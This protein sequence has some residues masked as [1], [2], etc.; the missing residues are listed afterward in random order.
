M[1]LVATF[2]LGMALA[3]AGLFAKQINSF[4]G[5]GIA[6]KKWHF[7]YTMLGGLSSQIMPI[8]AVVLVMVT[9]GIVTGLIA[10][11]VLIIGSLFMGF[12]R[13]SYHVKLL[14]S[15]IGVPLSILFFVISLS[16]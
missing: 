2:I 10:I 6:N 15:M 1:I 5:L 16:V 9:H 14:V 12:M 13:P 7:Y 8:L 3:S 11:L 4:A